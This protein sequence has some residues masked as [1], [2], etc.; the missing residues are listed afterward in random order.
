MSLKPN[1]VWFRY[2]YSHEE[3]RF[4]SKNKGC[5]TQW[6]D[7]FSAVLEVAVQSVYSIATKLRS[8]SY[9]SWYHC[10]L[11]IIDSHYPT[12][13]M[14]YMRRDA[15]F[16]KHASSASMCRHPPTFALS[17]SGSGDMF[18]WVYFGNS[19]YQIRGSGRCQLCHNH[20]VMRTPRK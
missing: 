10:I 17:Q 4:C 20:I 1:I 16:R 9:C 3:A 13:L 7:L 11:H 14:R 6:E 5:S 2:E 8:S 18:R 12:V 15:Q 19:C